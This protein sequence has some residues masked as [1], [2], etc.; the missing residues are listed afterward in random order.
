MKTIDLNADLGEADT[1][2]WAKSEYDMLQYI[3]SANIACGGH[4]GTKQTMKHIV[5][6]AILNG[7]SIGAHPGYPDKVHF[8]RKSLTLGTDISRENLQASLLEQII[9]LSEIASKETSRVSYIKPHGALYNDAVNDPEKADILADVIS[10][11]DPALIFMGAPNS[12]MGRAAKRFGLSFIAEGF[13]DRRY[14]DDGHLLSRSEEGAVISNQEERINQAKSLISKQS[15]TTHSGAS[16]SLDVQTL[17]LHGDSQGAVETARR[18]RQE[19]E[20]MDVRIAAFANA[21]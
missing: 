12:E 1:A 19:I 4:A 16:L 15:V 17:C 2:D 11:I 10:T 9:T 18:L 5:S 3:S 7:V 8:G 14:T 21:A 6:G 20:N 13:I